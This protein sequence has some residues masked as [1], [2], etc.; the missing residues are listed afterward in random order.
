MR[1]SLAFAAASFLALA[2]L[3]AAAEVEAV[4]FAGAPLRGELR[5]EEEDALV[6]DCSGW[7]VRLARR[8]VA[9][10]RGE[11]GRLRLPALE[12]LEDRVFGD[13][14]RGHPARA[15]RGVLEALELLANT[16][17]AVDLEG[18]EAVW[19][20]VLLH[21][22]TVLA[23]DV[24]S[25]LDVVDG[26]TL[27][28]EA[29][30]VGPAARAAALRRRAA[31]LR[32][33]G[34]PA[35]ARA[36]EHALGYVTAFELIG[37]F[38]NE[39]GTGFDREDP[40]VREAFSRDARYPGKKHEVAWRPQAVEDPPGGVIDLD[41]CL[42]PNDQAAAYAL[43]YLHAERRIPVAL[44][45]GSD[46]ALKVWVNG[47]QVLRREVR[48]PHRS[49][50]DV[51][52]VVLAPGWNRVLLEVCDQTG[53]WRFSL[54]VTDPSGG[55]AAGVRAANSDEIARA[56]ETP[57]GVEDCEVDRG[58]RALASAEARRDPNSWRNWFHL[59]L[60][61]WIG[62]SHSRD[63]H[64]DRDA[65]ERAWA[66]SPRPEERRARSFVQVWLS[67]AL[68]ADEEFSVNREDNAR[69]ACLEAAL[70]ADPDNQRARV[71]LASY[72]ANRLGNLDRARR[73]VAPIASE[74]EGWVDAALILLDIDAWRGLRPLVRAAI[75]RRIRRMR[76]AVARHE[77]GRV[78]EVLLERQLAS[79][80]SRG[81]VRAQRALLEELLENDR[82]RV[83]RIAALADLEERA[84][85]DER[86]LDLRRQAV[87]LSPFSL[88][89]RTALAAHLERLERYEEAAE[90]LQGALAVAPQ[91]A[92]LL[93]LLARNADRR[94]E[95]A[96]ADALYQEALAL[97]PN[98][99]SLRKYLDYRHRGRRVRRA[100]FEDA[101]ALDPAP[102]AANA[103]AVPLDARRP[104]R[105]LFRQ[106]VVRLHP[107]G[108]KSEFVQEV[109]RVEN[110]PGARS[111]RRYPVAYQ[112]DQQLEFQRARLFHPDGRVEEVPVGRARRGTTGEFTSRLQT[113]LAFPPLT[114]GDVLAVRYR[115]DDLEQG[116]F[117]DY[118]GKIVRFQEDARIDR[119]RFVVIAP[120]DKQL[121]FHTPGFSGALRR[122]RREEDDRT[123][124][125]FERAN[126]PPLDG[127]PNMPWAKE[128]VPQVQVSTFADWDAFA[129]WYWGLVAAQHEADPAIRKKVEELLRGAE[130]REEKVRRIYEYVVTDIRYNASWE[131]GVHGF[132]PYNATKIYARKFG[133]CKDKATLIG[134]MLRVAGIEAWPVLIFGEERRGREDLRLPL[135]SHFNHCI[136][137]VDLEGDRK[138]PG[139]FLD[140]TAE[141]HPYGTLPSMDYGAQAVVVTPQGALLRRIPYPKSEENAVF[142]EHRLALTPAGAAELRSTIRGTGRYGVVLRD[143]LAREG[144]RKESLGPQYGRRFTG[145]RV[146]AVRT[147]DLDDLREPVRV[148]L[149]VSLPKV[150]RERPDG[151]LELRPLRSWLFDAVTLRGQ[152]LSSLAAD[153]ERRFDVILG[154]PSGVEEEVV[155]ELPPNLRVERL[156][157]PLRLE[158]SFGRYELEY[159]Q[160]GAR[161]RLRRRLHFTAPRVATRDYPAFRDFLRD[162]ERAEAER[163]VLRS[164]GGDQ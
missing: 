75:A 136:S 88:E 15:L 103:K 144:L 31:A 83:D 107:N 16:A 151:A 27:L 2:Q 62:Q 45:L 32:A 63:E 143:L 110:E 40:P 60:L 140:G 161:V 138:K 80:R 48:R 82:T 55:P 100:P 4:L 149:E 98:R 139:R 28:V 1:S 6:L 127:E 97:D 76:E 33:L 30:G 37:P 112:S 133:D 118:F 147:S 11:G 146:K 39:R 162:I 94:G 137:W 152:S 43:T 70:A 57:H 78:D 51:V 130:T 66:L 164:E 163:P 3:G 122:D 124:Y 91:D 59:G 115:V 114:P 93:E 50:Q 68:E 111:M 131:F 84:G 106:I 34:R 145:A 9:A 96:R 92:D 117:G 47:E 102:L 58:P 35:L 125:V 23:A 67:R 156:P 85:R 56:P 7:E 90:V 71:L 12:G 42:R 116:F 141:H 20:E 17:D 41:A 25:P 19:A 87:T 54:R 18:R 105:V 24:G 132:K 150:L 158:R 95:P 104:R 154:V 65:L 108:T 119:M 14:C 53:P 86:A 113:S 22:L 134:T 61:H 44:R 13:A 64:P 129:R 99:V 38:D 148:E 153:G 49:D 69:R 142:E 73:L 46:E 74:D 72:Y 29:P 157:P 79:A 36:D 160:E 120:R 5:A 77:R 135:I 128:V 21:E 101:W 123:V 81:D 89:L 121:N 10:L 159:V 126:V 8:A 155:Y 109:V 26:A 52:G